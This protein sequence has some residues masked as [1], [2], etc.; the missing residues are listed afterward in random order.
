MPKDVTHEM[1]LL[2][3]ETVIKKAEKVGYGNSPVGSQNNDLYLTNLALIHVKKNLF[4]KTKEVI[5]HPL[6]DIRMPGGKPDVK[7]VK[8]DIVSG[9]VDIYFNYGEECF[10]FT[11]EKDAE[12]WVADIT[13]TLTGEK[14]E[15]KSEF[16]DFE[17]ILGMARSVAATASQVRSAFG[18]K[19]DEHVACKCSG[20]GASLEGT[21]GETI[22][23]PYCGTFNKLEMNFDI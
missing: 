11:W 12:D 22:Q 13:E 8:P 20:C 5:R 18:I 10:K 9:A 7:L 21:E 2:P 6:S 4:G 16:D 14:V 1:T 3:D 17:E 15:R 23:C 19:S